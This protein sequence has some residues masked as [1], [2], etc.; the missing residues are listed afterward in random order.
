MFLYAPKV[1]KDYLRN[2]PRL[3]DNVRVASKVPK[4]RDLSTPLVTIHTVPAPST[5]K[6]EVLAWRW[7]IFKISGG[8]EMEIGERTELIRDLVV[9]SRYAR[10]GVRRV[11][12]IGDAAVMY[13]ADDGTPYGQ[14]TAAVLFRAIR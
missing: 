8:E 9:A 4:T 13:D 10:I 14:I 3:P 6:P 1:F 12:I 7:L 5:E 2:S 11:N